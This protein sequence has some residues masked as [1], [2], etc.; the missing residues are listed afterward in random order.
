MHPLSPQPC[1]CKTL[2]RPPSPFRRLAARAA[3]VALVASLASPLSAQASKRP[4][5]P[6]EKPAAPALI[7]HDTD[8]LAEA[9]LIDIYKLIG[10]GSL[11][12]ALA[13]AERLAN[14][15]PHFQLAQLVYGDLLASRIRPLRTMGD[16]PDAMAKA[17]DNTLQELREESQ[18]RVRALR[19]RP[20]P[21]RCLRSFCNSRRLRDMRSRSMRHG[22]GSTSSRT[23]ARAWN[24][25]RTITSL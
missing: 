11:R 2:P 25:S 1:A 21:V 24:W 5:A 22:R 17:A 13:Q 7:Q 10:K 8:G 4:S 15:L 14:D 9:R 3:W 6:K 16:V 23:A 12:D 18:R 19:E 20:P